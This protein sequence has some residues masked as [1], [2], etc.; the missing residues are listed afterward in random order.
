MNGKRLMPDEQT[1]DAGS[2]VRRAC[3]RRFFSFS[4][5]AVLLL[6]AGSGCGR[7]F[8]RADL[9]FANGG[10]AETLDPALMTAQL[11]MRV[12]YALFEGLATFNRAGEPV[13]G[14]AERWEI[15]PDGT[16]YTFH[17]RRRR[18]WTNGARVTA[19]RFRQR[20]AARR[21][22]PRPRPSTPT[23]SSTSR[24]GNAS[25]IPAAHFTDFS[26]VGVHAVDD[27]TLRVE[28]EHPTP[29]FSTCAA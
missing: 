11:D 14:V 29:F 6:L 24:T 1:A 2:R 13:P 26:Q 19:R 7:S 27:G 20:L 15:S 12:A 9:V 3:G 22:R 23:S 28:L 21:S 5:F 16:V 8:T 25:T 18:L 10:E 17:L 4:L